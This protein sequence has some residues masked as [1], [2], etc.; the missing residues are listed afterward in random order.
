[1]RSRSFKSGK[2]TIQFSPPSDA[3]LTTTVR[4]PV[5]QADEFM[6]FLAATSESKAG[7]YNVVPTCTLR[8]KSKG[9]ILKVIIK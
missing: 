6:L 2:T 7:E 8:N 3:G 4:Q 5:G 1:V 9:I